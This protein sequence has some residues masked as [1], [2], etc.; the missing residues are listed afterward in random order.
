[1]TNSAKTYNEAMRCYAYADK[2]LDTYT[3]VTGSEGLDALQDLLTDLMHW[4]DVEGHDFEGALYRANRA[5]K[6]VS[7]VTALHVEFESD[8][9]VE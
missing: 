6:R 9:E 4:A 2:A 5:Y 7:G 8:E 1:M 3:G